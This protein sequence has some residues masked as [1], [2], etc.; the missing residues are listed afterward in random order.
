MIK[1][2]QIPQEV[3][4]DPDV[5]KDMFVRFVTAMGTGLSKNKKVSE[6]ILKIA[7]IYG[8]QTALDSKITK[9]IAGFEE[10]SLSTLTM[11]ILTFR[12]SRL[13]RLIVPQALAL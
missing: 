3:S 2:N 7:N 4:T 10:E 11:V 13:G 12:A 9:N 1:E 6:F 8:L 5:L